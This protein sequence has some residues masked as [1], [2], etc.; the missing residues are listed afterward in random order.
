MLQS[1]VGKLIGP[2]GSTIK[3]IQQ[4]FSVRMNIDQPSAHTEERKLRITGEPSHVQ[5]VVQFIWHLVN[6]AAPA[7]P[8]SPPHYAGPLYLSVASSP[9]LPPPPLPQPAPPPYF[10]QSMGLPPP[11]PP[12]AVGQGLGADGSLGRLMPPTPLSNGL[13]HQVCIVLRPS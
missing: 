7:S 9:P 13:V 6:G 1:Q 4:R 5:A 3:D 8:Q 11:P 10:Y 12:Q 2:G